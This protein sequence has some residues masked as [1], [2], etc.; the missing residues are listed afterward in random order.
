MQRCSPARSRPRSRRA[1]CRGST[2]TRCAP[3][4]HCKGG[5]GRGHGHRRKSSVSP[6]GA[7]AAAR[8]PDATALYLFTALAQD[9]LKSLTRLA[10]SSVELSAYGPASTTAT[11]RLRRGRSP[12]RGERH[13]LQ[14]RHAARA[15]FR[16]RPLGPVSATFAIVVDEMHAYRGIFG[17]HVALVPA[18]WNDWCGTTAVSSATCCA[19]PR[20]AIR[21]SWPRAQ[22][23]RRDRGGR[24][25]R[26]ARRE[27]LRV[28]EPAV[29]GRDAR[30]A[31]ELQRRGRSCLEC[32]AG[33]AGDRSPSRA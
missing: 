11:P 12:R 17:S 33:R 10:G 2:R 6:A 25:R 28:L 16:A 1:A 30:R 32:R 18:D 22:W 9:Q 21:A 8:D 13:P 19:A 15:S 20:S 3:S 29:P 14:P 5:H 26:A 27:A 23:A 7:G 4:K 24:R 31:A